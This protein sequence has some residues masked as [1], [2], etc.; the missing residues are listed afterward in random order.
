MDVGKN[1]RFN[2]TYE[3]FYTDLIVLFS[4]SIRYIVCGYMT[5]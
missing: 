1:C 3:L 2:C 5:T 4:Y